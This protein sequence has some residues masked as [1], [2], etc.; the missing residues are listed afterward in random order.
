MTA[1]GCL[2]A[3]H[4]VCEVVWD[5]ATVIHYPVMVLPRRE[6]RPGSDNERLGHGTWSAADDGPARFAN[7]R[8]L[9]VQACSC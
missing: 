2:T 3:C 8:D 1:G 5:V 9:R 6:H 7:F 4:A